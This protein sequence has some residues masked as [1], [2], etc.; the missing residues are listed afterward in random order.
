MFLHGKL[1]VIKEFEKLKEAT[2]LVDYMQQPNKE[3]I[4]VLMTEQNRVQKKVMDAVERCGRVCIF[5]HMFQD[6][7]LRWVRERLET[8]GV[9]AEEDA[10]HYI[11]ELSGTGRNELNNQV[12]IISNYLSRGEILTLDRARDIVSQ[13]YDHTVFDL[14]NAL[15]ISR[16]SELLAIFHNL[17]ENGEA[18]GKIYFFCNREIQRLWSAWCLSVAGNSFQKIERTLGLRKRDARRIQNLLHHLRPSHF[19]KL[20]GQL[21][22][23]DRTLKSSPR[24]L[25][26][27]QFQQFIAGLGT[28]RKGG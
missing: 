20:F 12:S 16:A 13:L 23:L 18:P 27:V 6:D 25:A 17:I 1:V 24:E 7:G 26:L 3:S 9:E 5:W 4:L 15:F 19:V 22:L 8:V 28:L 21:H 10:L 2:A 11:V 14:C